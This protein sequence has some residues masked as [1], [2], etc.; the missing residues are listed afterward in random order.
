M[1]ALIHLEQNEADSVILQFLS[2]LLP[3]EIYILAYAA[4]LVADSHRI[5]NPVVSISL[6]N[7]VHTLFQSPT[8]ALPRN[9]YISL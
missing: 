5:Q 3:A 7:S 8:F 9:V 4:S 2:K 1:S 6:L